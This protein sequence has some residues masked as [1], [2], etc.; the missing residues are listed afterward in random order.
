M[1]QNI[2]IATKL[3]SIREQITTPGLAQQH[4]WVTELFYIS[5][6]AVSIDYCHVA[7]PHGDG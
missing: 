7:V 6:V 5:F 1:H 2:N 4:I 3:I